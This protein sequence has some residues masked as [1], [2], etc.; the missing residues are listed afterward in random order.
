MS[1]ESNTLGMIFS[2]LLLALNLTSIVSLIFLISH[3]IRPHPAWQNALTIAW[4][5]VLVIGA[6]AL[7]F[8]LYKANLFKPRYDYAG[9]MDF[10][11]QIF[12]AP[13]Y[14]AGLLSLFL[15]P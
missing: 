3:K 7:F 11:V 2:I 6:A 10:Y 15:K 1:N 8:T 13:M 4:W 12:L 5:I 9:A 14:V